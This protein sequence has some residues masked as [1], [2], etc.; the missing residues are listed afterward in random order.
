LGRLTVT[1]VLGRDV[2]V[3][4]GVVLVATL[5]VLVANLLV[6]ASYGY[7]NPRQRAA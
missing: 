4:L 1:A 6:D 3:V 2:P 5:I 7:F